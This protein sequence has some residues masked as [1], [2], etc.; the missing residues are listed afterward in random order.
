MWE[1]ETPAH[2]AGACGLGW[3]V[4][5]SSGGEG[6]VVTFLLDLL[7]QSGNWEGAERLLEKFK[8]N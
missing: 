7:L 4:L 5:E 1:M 8:R 2:V 3:R 6:S